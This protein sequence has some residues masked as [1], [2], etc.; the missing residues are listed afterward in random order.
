VFITTDPDMHNTGKKSKKAIY[1]SCRSARLFSVDWRARARRGDKLVSEGEAAETYVMRDRGGGGRRRRVLLLSIVSVRYKK[2][3]PRA[4]TPDP[5]TELRDVRHSANA[6][7]KPSLE[8]AY[9]SFF[10]MR[11]WFVCPHFFLRQFTARAWRRA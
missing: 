4:A 5:R 6:L 9:F 1:L 11:S 2:V 8:T 10:L 7:S 3:E